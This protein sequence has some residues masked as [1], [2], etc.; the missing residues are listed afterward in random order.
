MLREKLARAEADDEYKSY[1]SV[2]DSDEY[3]SDENEKDES[4]EEVSQSCN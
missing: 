1:T 4:D 3:D 2:E